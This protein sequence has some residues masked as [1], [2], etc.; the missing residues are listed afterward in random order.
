TSLT[1][2]D[3]REIGQHFVFGFHGHEISEDVKVLIRDYHVGRVNIILMKR[4]VQ[5]V[6]QVHQLVQSL[7]Q[8]AKESGHPRPLMIGID[9]E[10]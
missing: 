5:D 9:Q 3:K 1:S 10:N 7:Q 4:N 6:K 2:A 8:L